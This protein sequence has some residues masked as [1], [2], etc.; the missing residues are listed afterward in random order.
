MP[1][2]SKIPRPGDDKGP[3]LRGIAR[4]RDPGLSPAAWALIVGGILVAIGGARWVMGTGHEDEVVRRPA[5]KR[6]IVV[7]AATQEPPAPA[8]PVARPTTPPPREERMTALS[9]VE[10]LRDAS[11]SDADREEKAGRF[12]QALDSLDEAERSGAPKE[13]LEAARVR[14]KGLLAE[15][16]RIDDAFA[17]ADRSASVGDHDRAISALMAVEDLARKQGRGADLDAKVAE[18]L[19]ARDHAAQVKNGF[20]SIDRARQALD[21]GDLAGARGEVERARGFVPGAPE[22]MKVERRLHDLER[23]P[24]GMLYVELDDEHGLYVRKHAVTNAE[25]KKWIDATG[26]SGSAPWKD[27]F[28]ETRADEAV[29]GVFTDSAKAFAQWR[30]ERLPGDNEW[31]ALRK[32][33]HLDGDVKPRAG[34]YASGFYTVKTP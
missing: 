6:T 11:L 24:E 4:P 22:L 21:V 17:A 31:P 18:I 15:Q 32:A 3:P 20:A 27:G 19:G 29:T 7:A 33:L 5:P 25:L 8:P 2:A 14:L 30:G 16:A 34:V 26:R 23:L 12:Q 1:Y 9:E 13:S 28:P 10:R